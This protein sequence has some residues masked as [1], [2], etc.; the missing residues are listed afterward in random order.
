MGDIIP[1]TRVYQNTISTYLQ[2][3]LR[4]QTSIQSVVNI[5]LKKSLTTLIKRYLYNQWTKLFNLKCLW[6]V[7]G[8]WTLA[9]NF[10]V[11]GRKED[12]KYA[13]HFLSPRKL[14][15]T[16]NNTWNSPIFRMMTVQKRP[17]TTLLS[18]FTVRVRLD[19]K[20]SEFQRE[21]LPQSPLLAKC[22]YKLLDI[23]QSGT[24][25]LSYTLLLSQGA[26]RSFCRNRPSPL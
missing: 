25:T 8:W 18:T 9:L 10:R 14:H 6:E 16:A 12:K 11:I 19:T 24:I 23:S 3:A 21:N 5:L 15:S 7:R 26:W 2:C 1:R 20:I 22:L 4:D 13:I 17:E